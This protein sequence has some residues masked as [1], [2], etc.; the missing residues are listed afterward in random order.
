MTAFELLSK[1]GLNLAGYSNALII[2]L[3]FIQVAPIKINPF[4]RM[5]GWFKKHMH[6]DIDEYINA[7]VKES[8]QGLY[9]KLDEL[10]DEEKEARLEDKAL[11]CRRNIIGFADGISHGQEYSSEQW[12]QAFEDVTFY[13]HYCEHHPDFPNGKAVSSINIVK[14]VYQ[15]LLIS[16]RIK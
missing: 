14:T 11:F 16:G 13:E 1:L 8:V 15:E 6:R 12:N 5:I 2:L 10:R 9:D 7:S 4:D 3:L